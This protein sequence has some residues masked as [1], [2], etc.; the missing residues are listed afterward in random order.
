VLSLKGRNYLYTIGQCAVVGR[1][2]C[3]EL[4]QLIQWHTVCYSMECMSERYLI[5]I[6]HHA[7]GVAS[8]RYWAGIGLIVTDSPKHAW[9]RKSL[10]KAEDQANRM[11]HVNARVFRI[12]SQ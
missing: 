6:D 5:E 3:N 12:V 8:R 10:H 9:N 7:H 11:K 1:L 2:N 4:R